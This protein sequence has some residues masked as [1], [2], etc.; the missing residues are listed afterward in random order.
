MV[1]AE[2]SIERFDEEHKKMMKQNDSLFNIML[3]HTTAPRS[4]KYSRLFVPGRMILDYC[5]VAWIVHY[6]C[7]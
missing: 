3:C 6:I 5:F 4:P 2:C 7:R 1:L